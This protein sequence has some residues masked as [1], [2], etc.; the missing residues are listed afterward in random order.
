MPFWYIVF[1]SHSQIHPPNLRE[2]KKRRPPAACCG[3]TRPSSR[4][5]VLRTGWFCDGV[6]AFFFFFWWWAVER[7]VRKMLASVVFQLGIRS[8]Q[9]FIF[10][11]PVFF[12]L[13]SSAAPGRANL[14]LAAMA[15]VKAICPDC[16]GL[17]FDGFKG[18]QKR[19]AFSGC[20][21]YAYVCVCSMYVCMYVS[22]GCQP[23]PQKKEKEKRT[24]PTRALLARN[25]HFSRNW[26]GMGGG[27]GTRGTRTR[28]HTYKYMV[29]PP[30]RST[31][32]CVL[33]LVT[34]PR[35]CKVSGFWLPN[36]I[37]HLPFGC[38]G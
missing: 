35:I 28:T 5:D 24:H 30:Q 9:G 32:F 17:M 34:H 1:L 31:I 38:T 25:R 33:S 16:M 26:D 14:V 11:G 37:L 29:P 21:T 27:I 7:Q 12:F 6:S 3:C 15:R 22:H 18:K 8:G 10:Y 36:F 19:T 2:E 4:S 23:P 20:P 13:F